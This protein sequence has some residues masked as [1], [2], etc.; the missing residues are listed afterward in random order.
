MSQSFLIDQMI[1]SYSRLTCYES[2]P[3]QFFLHYL[4]PQTPEPRF[5]ASFG[6]FVHSLLAMYYRGE[7]TPEELTF[8]YVA[9]YHRMVEG[10]PPSAEIGATFYA[11]GLQAVRQPW[12]P[13]GE[14]LAVEK[15][16]SFSID[17][18]PFT[19]FIDLLY[20][21]SN[22]GGLV[23]CDHKSHPLK[24]RSKRK[25][26]TQGDNELDAYLR[27]LY[28]YSVGTEQ[29]YGETPVAMCFNCYRAN[30]V[31]QEPFVKE[32]QQAVKDWAVSLIHKIRGEEDWNP[33][34]E[35]FQCRHLCDYSYDCE[36]R[37]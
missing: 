32:R 34:A 3:Y 18:Y 28:L 2:C 36:W 19:G 4:N 35:F 25:T 20:R 9:Q 1:W 5:F 37:E 11:Q 22:T 21:D 33:Y 14:I 8:D 30:R 17:G 12:V 23:I 13:H 24:A 29:E 6:G 10:N 16:L 27:Q 15:E 7:K 31:I 26:P